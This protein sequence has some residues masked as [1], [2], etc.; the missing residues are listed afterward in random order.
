MD[1]PKLSPHHS[2]PL[3]NIGFD[4]DS[5][6]SVGV[7]SLTPRFSEVTQRAD[8]TPTVSTV[9]FPVSLIGPIHPFSPTSTL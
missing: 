1:I 8:S 3:E 9:Y 5:Y 2:P 7:L 6:R 4:I